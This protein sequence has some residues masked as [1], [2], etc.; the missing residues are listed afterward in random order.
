MPFWRI[1]ARRHILHFDL[2]IDAI[3]ASLGPI[4]MELAGVENFC[5]GI[6]KGIGCEN[7]VVY[8]PSGLVSA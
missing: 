1:G 2:Q 8:R 4:D 5:I 6:G 3:R 7:R